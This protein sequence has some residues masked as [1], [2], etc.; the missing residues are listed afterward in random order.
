MR[1]IYL[2]IFIF[3]TGFNAI[4]QTEISQTIK[5]KVVDAESNY[6]LIGV[7][8]GVFKDSVL[9]KASSTDIDGDYKFENLPIGSYTLNYNML[10]YNPQTF[11]NVVLASGKQL[12]YNVKLEENTT[13]IDAVEV[14]AYEKEGV[15][16]EMS[17][18]SSRSFRADE[19][20]KY[21][22]SRQDPARMASNFAG[23]QGT[24][25]SRNDIV[26]RGN[27]PLGLLWRVEGIDIPSPN[28][29]SVAGSTGSPISV[30]NNKTI[31]TS[32]FMTG[33]FSAEYGNALSGVFDLNLKSGNNEKREFTGQFGIF[34]TELLAEGPFSKKS[35]AS[36]MI[37][38]RYSTLQ[39]FEAINFKLGTDA[40]PKYQDLTFKM[41]F[42]TKK[43]GV[44]SVWG[45]G[46]KS[47]IDIEPSQYL[48][49]QEELYGL[50]DRDQYFA[51]SMGTVG[52]T[53]AFPINKST[54][55]KFVIAQSGSRVSSLHEKIQRDS[56]F[57]LLGK[58]HLTSEVSGST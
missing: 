46:G 32:D 36:Y 1:H 11:T 38:Y 40:V 48:E 55:T 58:Y 10:G 20:E 22:G 4:S 7:T 45:I 54:F 29:F 51:T 27:S 26:V 57:T 43:T 53:H 18:V 44:F 56:S 37:A 17:L 14:L 5:G 25:D 28:H 12:I 31:A 3:C 6:P 39:M 19:T 13:N 35:K 8:V 42:P 9:V 23:V 2:I 34:G 15:V 50:K 30:L 47:K 24:D 52:L 49:P 21:A 33:A 41:N 16:N